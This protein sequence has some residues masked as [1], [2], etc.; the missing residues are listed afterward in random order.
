MKHT[1]VNSSSPCT[2]DLYRR[3]DS[4]FNDKDK[5]AKK[6]EKEEEEENNEMYKANYLI[7][8]GNRAVMILLEIR[9][10]LKKE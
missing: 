9:E 1:C 3:R 2:H 5:K 6:K 7:L 8:Y 4:R 10:T